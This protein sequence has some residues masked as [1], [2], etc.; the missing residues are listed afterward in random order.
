MDRIGSYGASLESLDIRGCN[1]KTMPDNFSSLTGL[2]FLSCGTS[3][4]D[5]FA[6]PPAQIN[7]MTSLKTL[8]FG[9]QSTVL[10]NWGDLSNLINL[11]GITLQHCTLIPTDVPAWFTNTTKLK[12]LALAS[13]FNTQDRIDDF[14]IS[15]YDFVVANAPISGTSA[16]QFRSMIVILYRST[17]TP[18][19]SVVPSG[20]YQQPSGYVQGVSNGT[21]A[22]PY[23]KV[24]VLVNQYDHTWNLPPL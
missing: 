8:F 7:S 17:V 3:G 5:G 11:E 20:S 24:W 22:S 12:V 14:V 18:V 21:P 4:D 9:Y 23:E 6:E 1:V 2:T 10:N 15:L 19:Q 16:D 13:C